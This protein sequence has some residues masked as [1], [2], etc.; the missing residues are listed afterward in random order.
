GKN[1]YPIRFPAAA[2][3]WSAKPFAVGRGSLHRRGV[4]SGGAA[5]T[6]ERE[7]QRRLGR[8][9]LLVLLSIRQQ[10]AAPRGRLIGGR[11]GGGG[12]DGSAAKDEA[13]PSDRR[14]AHG[15]D[16]HRQLQQRRRIGGGARV[17]SRVCMELN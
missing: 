17:L 12:G 11:G 7:Q 3:A 16:A 13:V 5:P 14:S 8:F 6:A 9:G 2:S 4:G 15:H 10:P 1:P